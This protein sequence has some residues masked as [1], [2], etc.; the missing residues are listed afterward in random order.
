MKKVVLLTMDDA[1][2]FEIYDSLLHA[3]LA[4]LGWRAYDVSWRDPSINW[5]DFDSVIIRSPWDYQEHC[6]D[7]LQVLEKIE[8]STAL[9]ANNIDL[10]K[11][12]INK[13]YLA[14]LEQKQVELVPTIWGETLSSEQLHGAFAHFNTDR[15]IIKPCISAGAF[16]TFSLSRQQAEEQE[17]QLLALFN[18]R[19]FMIQPFMQNIVDEGE[20]SIFFFNNQFSHCILKSPKEND[21]RVQEEYGGRL[22]QVN[23]EDRLVQAS[24]K[25]LSAIPYPALYARL[26]FVRTDDGFAIMEAELIEPSLY[27]NMDDQSAGRFAQAFVEYYQQYAITT[28]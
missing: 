14:E 5:N 1:G 17:K 20:Y 9:L 28:E 18:T 19:D 21:F 11:W 25:V 26:D 15:I 24:K 27:F 16:D 7:F 2:S 10:V 8:N 23:P 4:E 12:N 22:S 6:E 13:R 3:P